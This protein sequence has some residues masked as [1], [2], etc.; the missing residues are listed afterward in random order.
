MVHTSLDTC[1]VQIH[2][3]SEIKAKTPRLLL[4]HAEGIIVNRAARSRTSVAAVAV[5]FANQPKSLGAPSSARL[6]A[7]KGEM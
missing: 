3:V 4:A 6:Y 2:L 1:G 5:V 7:P